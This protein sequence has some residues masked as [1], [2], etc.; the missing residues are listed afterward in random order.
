MLCQTMT[1]SLNELAQSQNA[2]WLWDFERLRIV[3]ANDAGIRF[4]RGDSLF[5][6]L[7]RRFGPTEAG[8]EKLGQLAQSLRADESRN[9]NIAFPSRG[10]EGMSD[11]QC[12]LFKLADG[13]DGL[14]IIV[15]ALSLPETAE[16]ELSTQ[17]LGAL[18]MPLG[19]FDHNG[20]V[21]FTNTAARE[22][23]DILQESQ[24]SKFSL[25]QALGDATVAE[26][27]ITRTQ[28][29]GTVSET[30]KVG[31]KYGERVHQI[32]MRR[33]SDPQATGVF[34]VLFEDVTERRAYE[35][36]LSETA[37]RLED[38]VT[39]AADFTW[40][41]DANMR[42]SDVSRDFE[43]LTHVE[44]N[45]VAGK[46]WLEIAVEH[47]VTGIETFEHLLGDHRPWRGQI[48]WPGAPEN[49]GVHLSGVPILDSDGK[50]AGY[51]GTGSQNVPKADHDDSGS[52]GK[53]AKK[54]VKSRIDT[55]ALPENVT[56]LHATTP[57]QTLD[58]DEEQAFQT[59]GAA[60]TNVT[61]GFPDTSTLA[62]ELNAQ[63]TSLADIMDQSL[64]PLIVHRNFELLFVNQAAAELLGF[65]SGKAVMSNHNVLSL[66][67]ASRSELINWRDPSNDGRTGG[68]EAAEVLS[69]SFT[70]EEGAHI[71]ITAR[72]APIDWQG[73]HALQ[74]H[75][76]SEAE[77][78]T[79]SGKRKFKKNKKH[80]K[81]NL[82]EAE[83]RAVL[84]TA[85]DGII[86][87][88]EEGNIESFNASAEAMFGYDTQKVADRKLQSLMTDDSAE[89]LSEYLAS[90][91]DSGL[92]SLFNEGREVIAIEKQGGEIPLFLTLGRIPTDDG[93]AKPKFC[94]VVRDITSWK[95]VEADLLR[96]K[97]SAEDASAQKSDFLAKIS[98]ELR[99]PLNAIIGFS[100]VMSSE[101]FGPVANKRYLG[102]IND[103]HTSGGHLLSL[104]N[105]LLDLS[106]IEA[107]KFE[108][109]FVSVDLDDIVTQSVA[110]MQP[111][112]SRGRV[113]IRSSLS[114][115]LPPVVADERAM[116]QI[117][118]NL[119]SNA[120]KFTDAGGQ[121]I[122]SAELDEAGEV[123]LRV[124][125]TGIGMN[126]E[127][128]E[129]A[130]EPFQQI[131]RSDRIEQEGTG[132]GLPL[133]QALTEANRASFAIESTPGS[134]TLVEITFPTTRVLTN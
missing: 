33:F 44:T 121:V 132:L 106:K 25:A 92:A 77:P 43:A 96:A 11:C 1:L 119:L 105:D 81:S 51:R 47:G 69:L 38:F 82:K 115:D 122:V 15:T 79:K 4:W 129:R 63:G 93:K 39:A 97:E 65:K 19:I 21:L 118:L 107:G 3:W 26:D 76:S 117:M 27:F 75:L 78:L 102:Y 90:F 6:L 123:K 35:R 101:K 84:D 125:D 22:V 28:V 41:M 88:D 85:T 91:A 130:L 13:R 53:P 59:I 67:P 2:A 24:A 134:G 100:E 54:P 48:I 14:L 56:I 103:I 83:L 133:T 55:N 98:H 95:K 16:P 45:K 80:R 99:T 114:P 87:L 60:L 74:M 89:K 111:Q 23:F 113:I 50:F 108:L 66:F 64:L 5:D 110:T 116:H 17:L 124:R 62:D 7:D 104:I 120:I 36:V 131:L 42:L 20:A 12:M 112:A 37:S 61:T 52:L 18:P 127:E 9:L 30:R 72:L 86:T 31:T 29:A 128:V 49:I 46:T 94:A 126:E 68:A 40:E 70:D 32:T 8:I 57:D 58:E 73:Q 34:L 109:D 10:E 71:E